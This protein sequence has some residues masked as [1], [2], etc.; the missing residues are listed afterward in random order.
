MRSG[1]KAR[2]KHGYCL[3]CKAWLGGDLVRLYCDDACAA[4]AKPRD[5]PRWV[6][7]R[8]A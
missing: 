8:G 5:L 4:F 7:G 1:Q 6:Y 3:S 2:T